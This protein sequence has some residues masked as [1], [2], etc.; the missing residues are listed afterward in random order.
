MNKVIIREMTSDDLAA[1][2]C[3]LQQLDGMFKSEHDISFNAVRTT[4]LEMEGKRDIYINYIAQYEDTI[5]GFIS[6][7]RYKT[8]FHKRGTALINE[9]II[10]ERYRGKG[11]GEKLVHTM[12]E[13]SREAG[14]N[15]VEVSTSSENEKAI[16][17]YKKNGLI[18]ESI[19][20]GM[21][22]NK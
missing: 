5:V 7:V 3:L 4:F 1:V 21:E 17:F 16:S 9:L 11:I 12:I 15:E 22:L 6:A 2:Q 19:L 13:I 18:D 14:L 20:L 8:F 10:D